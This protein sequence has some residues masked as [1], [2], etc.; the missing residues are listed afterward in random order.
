[1]N[2]AST[3]SVRWWADAVFYEVPVKAFYDSDGNG[4]G[5]FRGLVFKLDYVQD[6]GVTALWLLPFL[7][8]PL[9]DDGFDVSDY[10]AVHPALGTIEDFRTFLDEAH[11]RRL[12]VVAEIPI[13]HT[14]VEHPWFQAARAAPPGSEL[15]EYY[16]WRERT[17]ASEGVEQNRPA[18]R[19]RDRSESRHWTWDAA[20]GAFYF[21]R[22]FPH[23]PD[24]NYAHQAVRDEI[25]R[26]LAFWLEQ[27][28]DGLC[29]NG[30][31]VL[32]DESGTAPE[33]L[34]ANHAALR[35]FRAI[36]ERD[37]PGRVL[38]AG[39]NAAPEL[40]RDYFGDSNECQLVPHL[41]LSE[42]LFVSLARENG[43]GLADV[44]RRTPSIPA[45]CQWVL[46]L[47]NH[48]ELQF[49]NTDDGE[50]E[51]LAAAYAAEPQMRE[52][53]HLA[54]RL[55][56]LV[57]ND[58]RRQE[59]LFALLLSLPGA[60]VIYYGDELGMGDNPFLGRRD[61]LRLPMP[62]NSDRHGGFSNAD[63]GRLYAPPPVDPVY[64]YGAVNVESRQRDPS[65]LFHTVRRQ[66]SVRA[67]TPALARGA[68]VLIETDN[69]C[70]LAFIRT[71]ERTSV[72]IAANFARS[73]QAVELDLCEYAGATPLELFG[74][75]PFPHVTRSPY[76]L[77]LAPYGAFWLELQRTARRR[78]ARTDGAVQAGGRR[79][80]S[81]DWTGEWESLLEADRRNQLER[82][83]LPD[84]LRSQRWFGGKA[85][86]LHDIALIPM[87]RFALPGPDTSDQWLCETRVAF[88][89]GHTEHYL[90]PLAVADEQACGSVL[91]R[92][93]EALIAVLAHGAKRSI[94]YDALA[95]DA[96]VR[97]M[98]DAIASSS[99]CQSGDTI[100]RG[101]ATAKAAA[102]RGSPERRL[103]V[104]R[105]PATSSNSLFFLGSRLLLKVYR[106]LETGANPDVEIGRFLT[107]D[108]T[109]ER[110]PHLAGQLEMTSARGTAVIAVLQELIPNRGDGWK[111]AL[112]E[113]ARYYTR[114]AARQ[115]GRTLDVD[116]GRS[117]LE[118]SGSSPPLGVLE[119]IGAYRR[120]AGVLGRR[121][122]EMHKALAAGCDDV[123]FVPEPFT[124]TDCDRL[125]RGAMTEAQSAL[126]LLQERMDSLNPATR[127]QAGELLNR[128]GCI[129]SL[130]PSLE[131]RAAG[132][133]I[134]VHGD[135]HLGQVLAVDDDFVILDFEG[136]PARP[137]EERMQKQS[138]LK[139]VAGMLRSLHYAAYAALFEFTRD[140]PGDF[141]RLEPWGIAWYQGVA[142]AFLHEYLKYANEA[143]WLPA[144]EAAKAG[145]LSA[146][147]LEKAFYEL[148]YELNNRPDWVRIPLR[149][150]LDLL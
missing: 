119:A 99:E 76:R 46:F 135:Y 134:R 5:D 50:A 116:D 97:R 123:S 40:A 66:I 90:L 36:V 30:A 128:A 137:L 82:A 38:Q 89:D 32:H 27:G 103:P 47:R 69:P 141:D 54:R 34:P 62:W 64:G 9:K 120:S 88:R 18:F 10:R 95:D 58:R 92:N 87:T 111:D 26:V 136:E 114:A 79:L 109:F 31:S 104:R 59:L 72:L 61:G 77:T 91:E 78:R 131:P 16:V 41:S 65:S 67:G 20:A 110:V 11:R 125:F 3:E 146:F 74:R 148:K 33:H 130:I 81:I 35:E 139:D 12:R 15:R 13:N 42:K 96:M 51:S 100:V 133:R 84:Y 142:G 21:H 71:L 143:R 70:V 68:L 101:F 132:Q 55:A 129:E 86:K 19:A 149:G 75:S 105:G 113:L 147:M 102:L 108:G 63:S 39:L 1:M 48:D 121:T 6:L 144:N 17:D 8:S 57:E 140:R 45:E 7:A 24:L 37:Y 52:R 53:F 126:A 145:L 112:D 94:L 23:Q 80:P 49:P 4:Y 107:D 43:E 22:F 56:P 25:G 28:L 85:R 124:E 29:L 117:L 106:R 60:P 73:A 2:D 115:Y 127:R 14:S 118:L 138:P 93:P 122:A 98:V 44:L 150:I 83:V